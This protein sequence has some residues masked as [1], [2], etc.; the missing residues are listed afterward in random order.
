MISDILSIYK[1]PFKIMFNSFYYGELVL[2]VWNVLDLLDDLDIHMFPLSKEQYENAVND[3]V[4]HAE[5][6]YEN[7]IADYYSC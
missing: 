4:A 2:D 7:Q 5:A 1:Q 6:Y 3:Q